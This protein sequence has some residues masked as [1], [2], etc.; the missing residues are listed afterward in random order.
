[1]AKCHMGDVM[2]QR[3]NSSNEENGEL[4]S[5][6]TG[7]LD[8]SQYLLGSEDRANRVGQS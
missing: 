4:H 1:M 2:N 6:D 8:A 5:N 3:I 7:H